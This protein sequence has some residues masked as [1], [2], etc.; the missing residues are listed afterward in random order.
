[1]SVIK[2][3]QLLM[4]GVKKDTDERHNKRYPEKEEGIFHINQ[5]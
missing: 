3:N 4:A 2:T 1:M 5:F